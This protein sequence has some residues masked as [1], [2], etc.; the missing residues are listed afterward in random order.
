MEKVHC[1]RCKRLIFDG[2]NVKGTRFLKIINKVLQAKCSGCKEFTALP[3]VLT[4]KTE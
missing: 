3:F 4:T 1:C 2:S